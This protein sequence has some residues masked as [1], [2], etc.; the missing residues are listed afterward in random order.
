[1]KFCPEC[2]SKLEPAYIDGEK[3]FV[4][5]KNDCNFIHWNNPIPVV[6]ALVEYNGNYIIAR[7]S[8]WPKGIFSVITGY[9]EN[10]EEPERA[11]IREVKEE[12][13]LESKIIHY[14][15]HY[16]FSE[17]NQLILAF[18]VKANGNLE[19]NHEL[20]E[21]KQLTPTELANYDFSPLYIT[22]KIVNAWRRKSRLSKS[23][24]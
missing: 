1:M 16:L 9:L 21:L 24:L 23:R 20:A 11:V 12:L 17:K 14:L 4:C 19:T 8:R 5:Q 10:R 6:A 18:E 2:G 7:N 22:E 13:G 15:G 3:R